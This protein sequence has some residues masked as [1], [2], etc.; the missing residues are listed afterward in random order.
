MGP[1]WWW[2]VGLVLSTCSGNYCSVSIIALRYLPLGVL[3]SWSRSGCNIT[4]VLSVEFASSSQTLRNF[5]EQIPHKSLIGNCNNFVFSKDRYG[6]H[7]YLFPSHPDGVNAHIPITDNMLIT[8]CE[9]GNAR[10]VYLY[11]HRFVL[12]STFIFMMRN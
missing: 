3:P 4:F 1:S 11:P 10:A 9:D 7:C 12:R 8:G 2:A 6:L 5:M